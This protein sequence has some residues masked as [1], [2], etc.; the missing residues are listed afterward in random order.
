MTISVV[1]FISVL[2]KRYL[3]PV[4]EFS[5]TVFLLLTGLKFPQYLRCLILISLTKNACDPNVKFYHIHLYDLNYMK[6][7]KRLIYL[8]EKTT[9]ILFL[10]IMLM[11]KRLHFESSILVL[12][13][14]LKIQ[15]FI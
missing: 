15:W 9:I 13:Y 5:I 11:I 14:V 4:I 7:G 10:F 8:F 12:C 3:T 1:Y 2:F 6:K